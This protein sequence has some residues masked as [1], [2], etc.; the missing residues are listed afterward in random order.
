[1][2]NSSLE[3]IIKAFEDRDSIIT[4]SKLESELEYYKQRL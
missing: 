4:D 1:M 3:K 2:Q